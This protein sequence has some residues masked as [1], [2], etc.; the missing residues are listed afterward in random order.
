MVVR[1]GDKAA[2]PSWDYSTDVDEFLAR[3]G[4]DPADLNGSAFLVDIFM[5]GSDA[6]LM[7]EDLRRALIRR[8][9]LNPRARY[10]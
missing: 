5:H 2:R 6:R 4:I 7:P 1:H 10:R 9:L 8:G 3:L